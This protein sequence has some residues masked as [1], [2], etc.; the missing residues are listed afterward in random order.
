MGWLKCFL[1]VCRVPLVFSPKWVVSVRTIV[2]LLVRVGVSSMLLAN[3]WPL[4]VVLLLIGTR[5]VAP[6]AII[7]VAVIIVAS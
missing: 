6:V 2:W 4:I 1:D 3:M 5:S 7:V